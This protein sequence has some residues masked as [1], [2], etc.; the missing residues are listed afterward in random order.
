MIKT[1]ITSI[2]EY[3]EWTEQFRHD[4]AQ[5]NSITFYRGHADIA[6]QLACSMRLP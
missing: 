3:L 1:E 4:A 2:A 6:Y 5:E